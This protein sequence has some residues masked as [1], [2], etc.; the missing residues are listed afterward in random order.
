MP[1]SVWVLTRT[2]G[3]KRSTKARASQ[4]PVLFRVHNY[5]AIHFGM[6]MGFCNYSG[7]LCEQLWERE[8]YE[9]FR[10]NDIQRHINTL[11]ISIIIIIIIIII[12]VVIITVIGSS[13]S[14]IWSSS[15]LFLFL[16]L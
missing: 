6:F 8:R 13:S 7:C 12:I 2:T 11:I 15:I 16:L 10:V 4:H 3:R 9:L 5:I 14:S 1:C